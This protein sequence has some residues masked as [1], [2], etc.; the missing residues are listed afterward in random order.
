MG[1]S[2]LSYVAVR[3]NFYIAQYRM[4]AWYLAQIRYPDPLYDLLSGAGEQSGCVQIAIDQGGDVE[5]L[6]TLDEVKE[7]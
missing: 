7:D 3:R 2:R 4:M 5:K 6:C 1:P